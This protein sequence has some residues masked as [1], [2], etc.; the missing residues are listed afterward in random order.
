MDVQKIKDILID[1]F[2]T[3]TDC[4]DIIDAL[5][6]LHTEAVITKEEYDYA[7]KHYD[8]ILIEVENKLDDYNTD[9]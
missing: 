3:Y 7:I 5:R 1:L 9:F 4:D 8:E 6:S 2:E